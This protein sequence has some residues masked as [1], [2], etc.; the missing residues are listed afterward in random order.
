MEKTHIAKILK[1]EDVTH[2]VKRFTVSKPR[3]YKYVPG[4][5]TEL[6]INKE[7]WKDKK[8][9]FTFTSL[10]SDKNLE[11]TIKIYKERDGVTD[12]VGKLKKGDEFIISEPFGA[13]QYK[14]KGVFIAGGAGI[15]PFIAILRQLQ[16]ENKLFGNTLIFSNKTEKDIILKNE[17]D[18]MKEL[19][20]IYTLTREKNVKYDNGRIDEEF[21]KK[22]VSDFGQHF[23]ICGPIRMVGE[24]QHFLTKLGADI[25]SI[26]VES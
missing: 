25:E 22:Y 10:N 16:K 6:S 4:Q 15:T 21:L 18:N 19:K 1:V 20:K 12:E 9:P 24:T 2:D 26:A 5:A 8:R 14:G 3:G 11:F 7:E 13:I 23:Y 17:F